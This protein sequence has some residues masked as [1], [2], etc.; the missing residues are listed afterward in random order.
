MTVGCA[1]VSPVATAPVT[2]A[3]LLGSW[4]LIEVGSKSVSKGMTLTFNADGSL[5]GWVGCNGLSGRYELLPQ[6]IVLADEIITSAGC[7]R[8]PENRV[9]VARAE[10]TLFSPVAVAFLSGNGARLYIRGRDASE[11]RRTADKGQ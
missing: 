10:K 7:T 8:W 11:F 3:A 5:G 4:E 6:R 9:I 2:K 1:S